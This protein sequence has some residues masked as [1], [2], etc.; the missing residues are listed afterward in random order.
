MTRSRCRHPFVVFCGGR[1]QKSAKRC[2][3]RVMRR[4]NRTELL[5][6]EGEALFIRHH[7]ALNRYSMPQDGTRHFLAFDPTRMVWHDWFRW[8]LAK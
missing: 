1:S 2:C 3:N 5:A 7:E 6:H 8:A 4:W